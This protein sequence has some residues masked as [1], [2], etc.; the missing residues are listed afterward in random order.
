M[1]FVFAL[2]LI[3]LVSCN[4]GR[5]LR[6]S[7]T[8]NCNPDND[9]AAYELNENEEEIFELSSQN[10]VGGDIFISPSFRLTKYINDQQFTYSTNN[11]AAGILNL[12]N[13]CVGGFTFGETGQSGSGS[14]EVAYFNTAGN[15][16]VA[17]AQIDYDAD[18]PEGEAVLGTSNFI[19]E[20]VSPET[21]DILTQLSL[22]GFETQVFTYKSGERRN[23]EFVIH[24]RN[25]SSEVFARITATR[26][27]TS[28]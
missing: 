22:L 17:G 9:I 18:K 21:S 7:A 5:G 14:F 10:F 3:F 25:T 27:A 24:A 28:N 12:R 8:N 13:V 1:K 4:N 20:I 26:S 6:L 11:L 2:F 19:N 23:Q 16:Q 15:V